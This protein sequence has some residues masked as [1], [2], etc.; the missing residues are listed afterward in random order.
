MDNPFERDD[1]DHRV[2]VNDEGQHSLWPAF[3]AIPPGWQQVFGPVSR[4][5]CV[6]YVDRE[7]TDLRPASLIAEMAEHHG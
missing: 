5:E 7:W 4:S 2:L 3:L 6:E 1:I